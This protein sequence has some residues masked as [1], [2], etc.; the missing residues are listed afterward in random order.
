MRGA[1]QYKESHTPHT[2]V[3]LLSRKKQ[4]S[5]EGPYQILVNS[6]GGNRPAMLPDI[7]EEDY[8]FITDLNVRAS[9]FVELY[10]RDCNRN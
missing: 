3:A 6:A 7:T 2:P 1:K 10:L 9:V 8:D 4:I 5:A